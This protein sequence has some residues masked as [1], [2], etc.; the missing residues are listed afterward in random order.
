M[1]PFL[2]ALFFLY[3][4]IGYCANIIFDCNGVL[5]QKSSFYAL[6]TIGPSKFFG[7]FN[8]LSIQETFFY[9]L[10]Q[11]KPRLP[12][13]PLAYYQDRILLPQIM[14]DWFAG[15]I[16]SSEILQITQ[17]YF[18][19]IQHTI[20][21]P[22]KVQ[23]FKAIA[24]LMFTPH[25]LA[26]VIVPSAGGLA[27]LKKCY[28]QKT[29]CG[30]RMHKIFMLTNWD[31]ES[32]DVLAKDTALNKIFHCL[33]DIMVSAHVNL[34]KPDPAI[35]QRAFLQFGIDPDQELTIYIDDELCN[36]KTAQS[37]HKKNLHCLH[38]N[39]F[40]FKTIKKE[41]KRLGILH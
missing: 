36:I 2:Y 40:N 32:F 39:N 13:T 17:Q 38:C 5:V 29:V 16:T 26:N 11:I 10:H 24:N 25:K 15:F 33:D 30:N 1:K 3:V 7:A 14:C 31:A 21:S 34:I 4:N 12:K 19:T 18:N 37:L 8:P 41:L 9:H 27:L 28:E 6:W 23:L 22:A 20:D 35:Y